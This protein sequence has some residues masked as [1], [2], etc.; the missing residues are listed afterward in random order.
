L[1][2]TVAYT[3]PFREDLDVSEETYETEKDSATVR[4]VLELIVARHPSMSRFVDI[5]GDEAQRRHLIVAV[6]SQLA[7]LSDCVHDGDGVRVLLPASG[8]SE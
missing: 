5:S 6:N 4:E 8:G 7:R 3:P 2:I 1:R